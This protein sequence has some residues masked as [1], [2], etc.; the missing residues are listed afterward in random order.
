MPSVTPG[1]AFKAI[2]YES[3]FMARRTAATAPPKDG[4]RGDDRS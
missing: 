4:E 1:E 3:P 2:G